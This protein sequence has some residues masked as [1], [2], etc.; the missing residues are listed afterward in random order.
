M[1]ISVLVSEI[2]PPVLR[3]KTS[4]SEPSDP[5]A[6]TPSVGTKSRLA[7]DQVEAHPET[8]L[9][10]ITQL[11]VPSR[12]FLSF[13]SDLYFGAHPSPY[14]TFSHSELI[15]SDSTGSLP[16]LDSAHGTPRHTLLLLRVEARFS[17]TRIR[18]P[19]YPFPTPP[20]LHFRSVIRHFP[21]WPCRIGRC[22]WD[23]RTRLLVGREYV[24]PPGCRHVRR[25]L[26]RNS[27]GRGVAFRSGKRI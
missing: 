20:G 1:L 19:H 5:G 3:E 25:L 11:L 13:L 12:S 27:L 10:C 21:W 22:C 2:G 17:W 15:A 14:S 24:G 18:L 23:R 7:Q 26:H 6:S 8:L 4:T 9:P 16:V